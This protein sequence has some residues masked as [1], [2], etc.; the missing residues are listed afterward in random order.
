MPG[1][2]TTLPIAIAL[3]VIGACTHPHQEPAHASAHGP[4]WTYEGREGP[5]AWGA[6]DPEFRQ[7]ANGR[8]QSPIDLD[9]A[10]VEHGNL[11]APAFHYAATRMNEV[12]NGHTIENEVASGQYVELAG[13]RYDL[14]Q[15]HF[16]HASEHTLD[17]AHFPLEIHLVHRAADGALVVIGVLVT[18][19]AEHG[20]LRVL[21][22]SLPQP[23]EAVTTSLD[24]AALLPE[25]RHYVTYEGSLTTPPCSE[26]VTWI[27][28]TTPVEA[29]AEQI[30]R[31][32]ARYPHN[33]RPTM[34]HNGRHVVADS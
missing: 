28:M 7:C 22:S 11:P 30:A 8:H 23:H 34:P 32:A 9:V 3:A 19:G 14:V 5:S 12:D 27:V 33:N 4:H 20:A 26:G 18:E 15:F 16:H 13:K 1:A 17:G 6:L 31:F 10:H 29:S 2:S 24:P 21:F 25:D